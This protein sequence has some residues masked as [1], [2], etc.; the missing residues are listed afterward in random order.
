[1]SVHSRPGIRENMP[2]VYAMAGRLMIPTGFR[3]DVIQS[4]FV[5]L[6]QAA[7][8]YD[9]RRGT[10]FSSYAVPFIVGEMRQQIRKLRSGQAG[11]RGQSQAA[12]V[13][14]LRENLTGE[15]G[16]EPSLRELADQAGMEPEEAAASLTLFLPHHSIQQDRDAEEI[17]LQ[18]SDGRNMEEAAV[19]LLALR[20][21]LAHLGRQERMIVNLRFF[22][23]HTQQ[24]TGEAMGLSQVQVSRLERRI[25]KRLRLFMDA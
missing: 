10:A 23:H 4:G 14:T 15:L 13:L 21:A 8:S 1:M 11:R 16:R 18:L 17:L 5:G 7:E 2:L 9:P 19:N 3:E 12:R 20:Q 24:Q 6:V 25:L 22:H